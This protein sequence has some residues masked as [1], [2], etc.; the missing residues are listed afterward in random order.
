MSFDDDSLILV[1]GGAG[2][3]GSALIEHLADGLGEGRPTVRIFDNLQRNTFGCLRNLP[4][5]GRFQLLEGDILDSTA[6]R[7]ALRGVDAI[8]H[9]AA[10]V[11]TPFSFDHPSTTQHVNQWGTSRLVEEALDAGVD[12]IVFASSAS[13]YGPGGRFTES[14]PVQPVGPYAESKRNAEEILRSARNRG[15]SST[16]LRL[17]TTY[18]PAPAIRFD[19]VPNQFAYQ[20]AVGRAVTVHGD[21]DQTRPI[22]HVDDA[23]RAILTCLEDPNGTGDETFNV[24]SA[25]PA[26]RE[27]AEVLGD[28]RPFI[29]IRHTDQ[30]VM[31]RFSLAVDSSRFR[32][33]G[34]SPRSTLRQGLRELLEEYGRFE[35]IQDD[36]FALEQA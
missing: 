26:I 1:T 2:Y 36:H 6:L 4:R 31:S 5:E 21:G 11:K 20:G 9:L 15:L 35:P 14:A 23:C 30:D 19:A 28:L 27:I 3:I 7:R 17:G 34:W 24:A 10:L 25:N 29:R 33:H 32:D 16:I 22:V 13:V 12:R 8:V 18:G